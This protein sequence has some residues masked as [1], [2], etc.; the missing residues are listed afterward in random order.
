[1]THLA[2]AVVLTV[3]NFLTAVRLLLVIPFAYFM[4]RGDARSAVFALIVWSGGAYN[5]FS[6]RADRASGEAL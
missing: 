1:M 2:G 6:R 4:A 3:A 5:R